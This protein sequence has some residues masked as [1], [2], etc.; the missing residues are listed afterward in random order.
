MGSTAVSPRKTTRGWAEVPY[1]VIE[2]QALLTHGEL[3]MSL[4]VLRRGNGAP[5]SDRNWTNWTGLSPRLKEMAIKGLREKGLQVDGR[6]DQARYSWNIDTWSQYVRTAPAE[7][8]RTAGRAVDPKPG[9]KVHQECRDKGCAMM[10]AECASGGLNLVTSTPVAKPVAQTE[11]HNIPSYTSE[12]GTPQKGLN[13]LPAT[14]IAKPVAQNPT[15]Y[16]NLEKVWSKT[17]AAIQAIFPIVGVSFLVRLLA[18]V[19]VLFKDLTD[20]EMASAVNLAY[21]KTAFRMKSEGL[22]LTTVPEALAAL[23]RPKPNLISPPDD[24][25]DIPD[26]SDEEIRATLAKPNLPD[27]VRS[28]GLRILRLRAKAMIARSLRKEQP[29]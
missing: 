5:I 27:Y 20:Q 24:V 13:L 1:S 25:D 16:W 18:V 9:A 12:T 8:P 21:Q 15:A 23:R 3:S 17:L 7:K 28:K 10:R 2:N 22:F 6:G 26:V 14:S 4:V 29:S 11:P 19:Q